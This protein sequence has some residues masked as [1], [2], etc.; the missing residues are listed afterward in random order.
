MRLATYLALLGSLAS[1][2]VSEERK[3]DV[4]MDQIE[5]S[6]RL[7]EGALPLDSYARY[8]TEYKGKIHGAFTT[9][10]E[11]RSPDTRCAEMPADGGEIKDIKCPK[12][13]DLR[14]GKRRWVDFADYPAVAGENCRAVQL[15]YDPE[16]KKIE[17]LECPEPL[18]NYE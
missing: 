16:A 13:A 2:A 11:V 14:L 4:A 17:H 8:Y 6:I 9:E 15:V 1:C 3:H 5:R 12:V 10:F 18:G 7:P